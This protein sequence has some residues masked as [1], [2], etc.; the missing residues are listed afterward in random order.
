MSWI[1]SVGAG[2]I[3]LCAFCAAMTVFTVGLRERQTIKGT[4]IKDM[5]PYLAALAAILALGC[6]AIL[7]FLKFGAW[8]ALPPQ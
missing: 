3:G 7:L 2:L 6:F 5:L 4:G 8:A 1:V